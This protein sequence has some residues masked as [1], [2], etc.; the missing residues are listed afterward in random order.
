MSPRAF[1]APFR[2]A[3]PATFR[4]APLISFTTLTALLYSHSV[5]FI[6]EHSRQHYNLK[7]DAAAAQEAVNGYY[8]RLEGAIVAR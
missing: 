8:A 6:V 4:G 5:K 3:F 1:S 2:D 7:T